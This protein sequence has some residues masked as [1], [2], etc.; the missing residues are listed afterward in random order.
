[1]KKKSMMKAVLLILTLIFGFKKSINNRDS[2]K[3]NQK[4]SNNYE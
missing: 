2:E 1:M 3:S 4:Y